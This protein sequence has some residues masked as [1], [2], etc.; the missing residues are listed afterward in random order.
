VKRRA[1]GLIAVALSFAAA[2]LVG[3]TGAVDVPPAVQPSAGAAE[4]TTP[5]PPPVP[6]PPPGKVFI[7]VQTNVGPS[8]F[9]AVDAFAAA[10]G[11]RPRTLQ[12]SQGWAH[13]P[14]RPEPFNA[15]A[16]RGMLPIVSWEPWDYTRPGRATSSGD[17]PAYRLGAIIDGTYD[18]YIRSWASGIA[19]LPYP[20]VMRFAHEMNGFWY[21]WCEQSNANQPG[22]YIFTAAGADNVA[23]LWSPNVTYPGAQPLAN[24][25]PGDAYVDWIGLSGYYGTAGREAYIGFE[26]IFAATFSELASFSRKPIVITETGATNATGRQAEWINDMFTQLPRHPEVIGVIW[27]EADKEVDWRIANAPAAAAAFAAN[28]SNALYDTAWTP[29]GIPRKSP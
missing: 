1:S 9:T 2:G 16:D 28:A 5:P 26:E 20:V 27:F 25:Y 4:P 6:F 24:L 7:G 22:Q 13:D 15:I 12:F 11:Y 17:Q 21:P 14:F 8:D 10:T 18:T 29:N 3:C 19:S 23:W